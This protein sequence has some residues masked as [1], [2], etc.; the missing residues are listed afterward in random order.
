[1]VVKSGMG[2]AR[3]FGASSGIGVHNPWTGRT[4]V[5]G[6]RTRVSPAT[7]RQ[8]ASPIGQPTGR[9]SSGARELRPTRL[10]SC[11]RWGLLLVLVLRLR[12][13]RALLRRLGGCGGAVVRRRRRGWPGIGSDSAH[14]SAVVA[15][16]PVGRVRVSGVS[17]DSFSKGDP[18]AVQ[19][20]PLPEHAGCVMVGGP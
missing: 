12:D 17:S 20:N 2:R 7:F 1:M 16:C 6:Q 10:C 9:G 15:P 8:S 13:R 14:A 19:E 3:A 4:G 18:A 5:V 11:V